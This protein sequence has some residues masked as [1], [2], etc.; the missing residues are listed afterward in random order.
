[1]GV[2]K[3][4]HQ[5]HRRAFAGN[6]HVHFQA[7]DLQFLRRIVQGLLLLSRWP[8]QV[9]RDSSQGAARIRG[10][11]GSPDAGA[12]DAKGKEKSALP[13]HAATIGRRCCGSA[14]LD[15][16]GAR[17]QPIGLGATNV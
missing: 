7:V 6:Q 2:G 16:G 17:R 4:M 14:P 8:W 11:M 5:Q 12:I 9:M 10:F 3:T 1:M 15:G 13:V